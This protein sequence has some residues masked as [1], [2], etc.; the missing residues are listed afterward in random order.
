MVITSK[1]VQQKRITGDVTDM[2]TG[3]PLPGVNVLIEGT[4]TGTTTDFDGKFSMDYSQDNQVLVFSYI[5]YVSERIP[6]AGQSS[7]SVKLVPDIT[8]LDEVVVVGYGT[9]KKVI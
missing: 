6:L 8:K 3:E 4:T 1:V 7:I 2:Q 9:Q 5:G